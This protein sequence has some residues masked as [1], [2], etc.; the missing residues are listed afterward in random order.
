MKKQKVK[1]TKS[2]LSPRLPAAAA[3]VI[4][5]VVAVVV[6][7]VDEMV[8]VDVVGDPERKMKVKEVVIMK[9]F[10]IFIDFYFSQFDK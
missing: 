10:E 6:A 9:M 7:V 1:Q 4:A 2:P 5:V 8:D 3:V